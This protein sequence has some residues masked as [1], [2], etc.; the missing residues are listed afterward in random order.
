[1]LQIIYPLPCPAPRRV[2]SAHNYVVLSQSKRTSAQINIIDLVRIRQCDC[3][4]SAP[5]PSRGQQQGTREAYQDYY[6]A[7]LCNPGRRWIRK[8]KFLG[9]P[10]A[11]TQIVAVTRRPDRLFKSSLQVSSWRCGCIWLHYDL[12]AADCQPNYEH[13]DNRRSN[14]IEIGN[15]CRSSFRGYLIL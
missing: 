8:H 7:F 6:R 5:G 4:G 12:F 13:G 11:E 2:R 14:V 10:R 9:N 15:D 3:H 1:M